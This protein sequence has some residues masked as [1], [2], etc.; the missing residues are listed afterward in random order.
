VESNKVPNI[1]QAAYDE[2]ERLVSS[3]RSHPDFLKLEAV[4]RIIDVYEPEAEARA[5]A[6]P[7]VTPDPREDISRPAPQP[8]KTSPTPRSDLPQT[9]SRRHWKR[10]DSQSA[11][12][13]AAAADYLRQKGKRAK[14]GEIY[15]AIAS[16]GV[17][18]SGKKPVAYV[19]ARLSASEMFDHSPMGG[20]GLREWTDTSARG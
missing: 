9:T 15:H 14:G 5:R 2:R 7:I 3:L 6:D 17:E 19:C 16:N 13:R 1:L 10:G 4:L 11:R 20:Y 18:V 8:E 12:I